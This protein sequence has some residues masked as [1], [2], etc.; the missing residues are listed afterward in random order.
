MSN[1]SKAKNNTYTISYI[2]ACVIFLI[3]ISYLLFVTFKTNNSI[4][5]NELIL[6]KNNK[7]YIYEEQKDEQLIEQE[8]ATY[9]TIIYDQDKNRIH[10]IKLA[11]QR[12]NTYK[13][14]SSDEF[15]FNDLM[16]R[17]DKASGYKKATGFD[18]NG[19]IIKMYG[20]GIC[21]LSSTLYNAAL[22]AKLNITE[23]H[24]HSRR[25]NY[26]P[27]NKDA[28][29][30]YGGP[31]LRFINNTPDTIIIYASTDGNKVTVTLKRQIEN[32]ISKP[33]V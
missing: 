13:L 5:D 7:I 17:M 24:A 19:N 2:I 15:S 3:I 31:N 32:K 8:I 23:R 25:V 18:S 27:K 20:G 33:L 10:N 16:G 4:T 12:L 21:Q 9:S 11:C 6:E 1:M 29:I 28:T 30:F 26:V 22:I 14:N